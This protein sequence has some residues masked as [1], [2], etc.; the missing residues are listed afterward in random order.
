MRY[1]FYTFIPLLGLLGLWIL[2]LC[3]PSI[4]QKIVFNA[5]WELRAPVWLVMDQVKQWTAFSEKALP[6]QVEDLSRV[7]SS[8]AIQAQQADALRSQLNRLESLLGMEAPPGFALEHLRVIH[9]EQ[10][11]WWHHLVVQKPRHC[12]LETGDGVIF[13]E[14]VVGRIAAVHLF[15]AVVELISSPSF[16]MIAHAQADA[17][18]ITYQGISTH[19]MGRPLGRAKN[20]P[21][22]IPVD[23]EPVL[24]SASLGG[25]FP[26]G[27]CVGTLNNAV[28]S[29]EGLYLE[30]DVQI[31]DALNRIQ[32]VS[33]LIPLQRFQD[34]EPRETL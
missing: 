6:Q 24:V 4:T 11:D 20:I 18:P 16:R 31:P 32:E 23:Q 8:Y 3:F 15:T 13:S 9:R 19:V 22:H 17:H 33:V 21:K 12:K 28:S 14:G 34:S 26:D 5:F 29:L 25:H 1:R 2:V 27:L 30:A 10:N 7:C